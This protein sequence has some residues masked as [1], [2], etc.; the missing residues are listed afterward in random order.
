[1]KNIFYYLSLFFGIIMLSSC[2]PN[3]DAN[4]DFLVGVDYDQDSGNNGGTNATIKNIKKVTTIDSGGDKVVATYNYSGTK[5]TGV[6]ADDNSFKYTISYTSDQ[7][8]KVDYESFD[9]FSGEKTV[10]SQELSYSGGKLATSKGSSKSNGTVVYQSSTTY[11]YT[12]DKIKNIITKVK[13]DTNTIELFTIQTDYTFNGNNVSGMKYTVTSAP[14]PVTVDPIVFTTTFSNYDTFKN[15]LGTLPMAF[16]LVSSHF[17]LEN[18]V[19]SGLSSNNATVMKATSNLETITST[20]K[21]SYDT[22][23]Y[24]FLGTSANGTVAYEYVK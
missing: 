21:Y 11:N 20:L 19:L 10:N 6:T 5:L 24:P 8:S 4:G 15:P 18:N 17:D 1:M 12:G 9:D 2:D 16:K 7:I 13:D 3:Q 23:G 22:D 14:G